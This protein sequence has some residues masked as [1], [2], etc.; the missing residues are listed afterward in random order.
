M[1]AN[2]ALRIVLGFYGYI[3]TAEKNSWLFA[4][5]LHLV[6]TCTAFTGGRMLLLHTKECKTFT[7]ICCQEPLCKL[8]PCDLQIITLI[9]IHYVLFCIES[10]CTVCWPM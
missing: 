4:F 8:L 3:L 2:G 9:Q 5:P 6:Y 7:T 1:N 10:A